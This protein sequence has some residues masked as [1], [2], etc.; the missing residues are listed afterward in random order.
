MT[1][2]ID[3]AQ[4]A[5]LQSQAEGDAAAANCHE[6]SCKHSRALLMWQAWTFT[7]RGCEHGTK[8]RS[9]GDWRLD[10]SVVRAYLEVY[11]GV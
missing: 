6:M 3:K 8:E 5:A 1:P 10:S 11:Q 4:H 7:K 2:Q 9:P